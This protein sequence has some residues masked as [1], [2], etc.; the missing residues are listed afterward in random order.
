MPEIIGPHVHCINCGW[1][2][3]TI[4]RIAEIC[5]RRAWG[6]ARECDIMAMKQA[7]VHKIDGL[8]I[9]GGKVVSTTTPVLHETLPT[10]KK[11]PELCLIEE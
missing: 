7:I 3:A 2:I 11:A 10:I 1:D 6:V 4:D 8:A 5:A 9:R